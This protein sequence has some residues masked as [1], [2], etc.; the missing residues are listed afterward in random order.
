M[1]KSRKQFK[2]IQ[3]ISR[4]TRHHRIHLNQLSEQNLHFQLDQLTNE[5]T[6]TIQRSAAHRELEQ[7]R[8]QL[9]MITVKQIVRERQEK[10]SAN[11]TIQ[12]EEETVEVLSQD[13]GK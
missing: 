6:Q 7:E 1:D 11:N 8:K 5:R 2:H 13:N 12:T 10:P 9:L 3:R 4:Q